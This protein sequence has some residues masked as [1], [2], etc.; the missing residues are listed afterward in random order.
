EEEARC[1][2]QQAQAARAALLTSARAAADDTRVAGSAVFTVAT[3][4]AIATATAIAIPSA[5]TTTIA[6]AVSAISGVAFVG[7]TIRI[8]AAFHATEVR[9]AGRR[10]V[11]S[12][13]RIDEI[14]G[15]S[16]DARAVVETGAGGV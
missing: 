16:I 3:G 1:Q 10:I 13:V 14:G 6:L 4:I 9:L 2:K 12:H 7:T 11:L 8:P 5:T 15:E